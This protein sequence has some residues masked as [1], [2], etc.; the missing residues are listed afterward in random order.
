MSGLLDKLVDGTLSLFGAATYDVNSSEIKS[1]VFCV[2]VTTL[3]LVPWIPFWR[4]VGDWRQWGCSS[5]ADICSFTLSPQT[6]TSFGAT[7]QRPFTPVY[8][9]TYK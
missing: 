1:T 6:D 5:N 7:R 4:N 8:H 9:N 2:A 3:D